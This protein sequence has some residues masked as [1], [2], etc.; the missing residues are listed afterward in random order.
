MKKLLCSI[1]A[2]AVLLSALVIPA[3]AAKTDEPT[4][5]ELEAVIKLV[6]SKIDVPEDYTEFSWNYRSP[7]YYSKSGWYLSWEAKD[8]SG[9]INVSCDS[10]GNISSF[11]SY[12]RNTSYNAA[13]PEKSPEEYLDKV[14]AFIYKAA[15]YLEGKI[16]LTEVSAQGL[17]SHSY[18]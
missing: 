13:L 9:S 6:R 5:E 8:Y 14:E 4:T 10:K 16:E 15:P 1:I 12:S 2:A 11:D 18:A 7:S 17:R 3:G